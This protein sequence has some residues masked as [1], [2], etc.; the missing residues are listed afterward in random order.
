[1]GCAYLPRRCSTITLTKYNNMRKIEALMCDAI[2]NRKSFKS[3]NTEVKLVT[4]GHNDHIQGETN[5]YLH[6]NWIAKITYYSD[7][8]D[9]VNVNNCG[10][11]S[12]TTKSR[13]NSILKTFTE[14]A[15]YQKAHTWYSYNY[16]QVAHDAL[17]PKNEWVHFKA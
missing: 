5:V 4:Y 11:E 13:I 16:R 2:R 17:F 10:W 12:S 15:V 14:W 8:P 7:K 3:G 9:Y 1:V 6:G